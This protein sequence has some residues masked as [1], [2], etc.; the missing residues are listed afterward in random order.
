[1]CT[2]TQTLHL[3]VNVLYRCVFC[4]QRRLV[5]YKNI[6]EETEKLIHTQRRFSSW[7][8]SCKLLKTQ[9]L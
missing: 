1:M 8:L 6:L 2:E 9:T 4:V 7:V 3:T 5:F